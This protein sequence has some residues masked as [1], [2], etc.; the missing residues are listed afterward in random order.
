MIGRP[1]VKMEKT[2]R[3]IAR[4]LAT[5]KFKDIDE[6]NAFL[7][8]VLH[9]GE[10][11]RLVA[12]LPADP[13]E[14]AQSLAF[15]AMEASSEKEARRLA[16]EALKLDPG[17]VDA[18]MV[19]I[20]TEDLD[21]EQYEARLRAAVGAAEHSLGPAFFE[22]NMGHFWGITQTRPYM[23]ARHRL[24]AV[25][26]VLGDHGAA[27][28]EFEGMLELNP[29]DNQGVREELLGLYLLTDRCD[30]ADRLFRQYRGEASAGFA[31]GKVLRE[32]IG[33]NPAR[34]TSALQTAL[35]RN[36]YVADF[37]TGR[38]R[39]P[40]SPPDYFSLG[41]KEEA[42]QCVASQGKAWVGHPEALEWL[43]DA[44]R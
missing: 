38:K 17:C 23:R 21:I 18:L 43:N 20:E 27:I 11:N 39:M 7:Q 10:F 9:S 24:A 16:E 8:Q 35:Q 1:S 42:M 31:W 12:E 5:R 13:K 25:L 4:L 36:R 40:A 30:G 32:W 41:S 37:M 29:G 3:A 28:Q 6:M 26:S 15:E 14:Q 33:G 2:N 19:L 22:E 34:P 44:I